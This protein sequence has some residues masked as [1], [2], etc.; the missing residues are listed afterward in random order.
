MIW[1]GNPSWRV[2]A[3]SDGME[4]LTPNDGDNHDLAIYTIPGN[5]LKP[6][7]K[8]RIR[9]KWSAPPGNSGNV[10][11][12]ALIGAHVARPYFSALAANATLVL[13]HEMALD[14][15]LTSQTATANNSFI[16]VN[17]AAAATQPQTGALVDFTADVV[18]ALRYVTVTS[19][20]TVSLHEWYFEVMQG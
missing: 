1:R 4:V 7:A 18:I 19:G 16:R 14:N 15:S 9:A 5:S 17:T 8:L 3:Q 2:F 10:G 6:N 11:V 13:E 12:G 20:D